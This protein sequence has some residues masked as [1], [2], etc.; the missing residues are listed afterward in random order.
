MT[1][2]EYDLQHKLRASQRQRA[3]ITRQHDEMF[4]QLTEAR[5]QLHAA[6]DANPGAAALMDMRERCAT[7]AT[8]LEAMVR[9]TE[10]LASRQAE[11]AARGR[12]LLATAGAQST[13]MHRGRDVSRG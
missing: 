8:G 9:I 11:A 10:G 1:P 13:V 4:V 7:M 6:R 12:D 3:Q 2:R 5:R